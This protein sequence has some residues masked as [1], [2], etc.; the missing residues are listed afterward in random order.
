MF[1]KLPYRFLWYCKNEGIRIALIKTCIKVFRLSDDLVICK[2][3]G[4]KE[5]VKIPN[6]SFGNP[7]NF[8][9]RVLRESYFFRPEEIHRG[10]TEFVVQ[11]LINYGL[12]LQRNAVGTIN[13]KKSVYEQALSINTYNESKYYQNYIQFL[14]EYEGPTN[15]LLNLLDLFINSKKPEQKSLSN[16]WLIYMCCLLERNEQGHCL[17]VLKRYYDFCS[18]FQIH[19]YYPVAAFAHK[20][21]ITNSWIDKAAT[22]FNY[23]ENNTQYFETYINNKNIAVVGNAPTQ[24]GKGK[25]YEIDSHDIVIRFNCFKTKGFESDYGSKT[26]AWVRNIDI[27]VAKDMEQIEVSEFDFIILEPNIWRFP[28]DNIFLD[29]FYTYVTK[30]DIP[31]CYLK[32]RDSLVR[33]IDAFPTSGALLLYN[34]YLYRKLTKSIQLYGFSF[35]D[36]NDDSILENKSF[37]HYYKDN[38]LREKKFVASS[39]HH[40]K[41]KEFAFLKKIYS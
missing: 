32:N 16:S 35:T 30:Y 23:L 1:T 21:G 17:Q 5:P 15:K 11:T 4:A 25:G 12:F 29:T 10:I 38:D 13:F 7:P 3:S 6:K 9:T 18:D 24:I 26:T 34:L 31:V 39:M 28:I 2:R 33:Q 20:N 37:S 8:L 41:N 14:W 22:V 27:A 36:S 19:L 40:D